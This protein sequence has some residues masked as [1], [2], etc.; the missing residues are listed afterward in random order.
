MSSPRKGSQCVLP[1]KWDFR[2]KSMTFTALDGTCWIGVIH[3]EPGLTPSCHS[4]FKAETNFREWSRAEGV[5]TILHFRTYRFSQVSFQF[6][7]HRFYFLVALQTLHETT[8]R[9]DRAQHLRKGEKR[10]TI[11]SRTRGRN[12]KKLHR[13]CR[14]SG[15]PF[16]KS[17]KKKN[18]CDVNTRHDFLFQDVLFSWLNPGKHESFTKSKPSFG[19]KCLSEYEFFESFWK[20]VRSSC[21]SSV[22]WWVRSPNQS[23][24]SH[25]F[26]AL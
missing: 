12:G 8:A 17:E 4:S 6:G 25:S 10:N 21:W 11:S 2:T 24:F 22:C 1:S 16:L 5:F 14:Q 19:L 15:S 20:K 3:I 9:F 18:H 7:V 26:I 13:V 23:Y